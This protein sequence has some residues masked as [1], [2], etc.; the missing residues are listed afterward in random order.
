MG[1][2]ILDKFGKI[3]GMDREVIM[4]FGVKISIQ[5]TGCLIKEQEKV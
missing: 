4:N 5:A 3:K 2:F 1:I